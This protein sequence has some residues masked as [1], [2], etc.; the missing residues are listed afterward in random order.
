MIRLVLAARALRGFADGCISVVLPAYLL[1]LGHG[2]LEVGLISTATLLGSAFT[3]LAVGRWGHR[4]AIRRLMLRAVR[5]LFATNLSE[6]ALVLGGAVF[7]VEPLGALQLLWINLLTD[8]FPAL[9]LALARGDRSVLARPPVAPG[10]SIFD[11]RGWGT[12]VRDGLLLGGVGAI[13]FVAGGPATAFAALP[14]A[15][16]GYALACRAPAPERP[17]AAAR[18]P[19]AT[20]VG[21]SFGLHA[22]AVLAPP[23]RAALRL[24]TATP[25]SLFGLS[26]LALPWLLARRS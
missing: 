18:L 20:V 4:F 5:F 21:A 12:L 10:S 14:A 26:A 7:G 17:P 11:R 16:L 15:Q 3:T 1:A 2:E 19:V 13:G 25:A 6:V 23:L 8:A 24:G 22:L 9:G